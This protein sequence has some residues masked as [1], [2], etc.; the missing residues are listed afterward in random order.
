VVLLGVENTQLTGLD[1]ELVLPH[2]VAEVLPSPLRGV[3]VAGL[4]GAAMST[5]DS[6][7]NASAAYYVK[8]CVWSDR[9][10]R[11]LTEGLL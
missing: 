1:P 3:V 7:V 4:L 11:L 6:D 9:H 2:V 10:P 5:L 8:V